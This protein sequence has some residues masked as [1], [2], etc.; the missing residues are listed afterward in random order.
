MSNRAEA[1][2]AEGIDPAA[3]TAW[4]QTLEL[5]AEP[6]LRIARIGAGASNLTYLMTDAAGGR[7]VLRRPPLGELLASAHDIGRE[8]RVLAA[9]EPTEVPTPRIFGLCADPEVS[10]VPLM[11]MEW[12]EGLV[13][14][15]L[16]AAEALSPRLRQRFGLALPAALAQV[17]EV[18]LDATGLRDLSTSKTPYAAR[19]LRRWRGQL[20]QSRTRDVSLLESLGQRLEEA[21]PEQRETR[22]VHGDFH[23]M[24][25]IFSPEDGSVRAILDWELCTL[26]DPLSDLGGLLAY[27]SRPEDEGGAAHRFSLLPG[28]PS[29][30]Q[31]AE[32]YGEASGR[33]LDD[34]GFWH[35]L[36]LWKVAVIS[37][38]VLDRSLRD[39]RNA[40]ALGVPS[41]ELIDGVA[42]R[43]LSVAAAAGF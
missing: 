29:R 12:V 18:D 16:G 34:L 3:V 2:G 40:P 37:E 41:V 1:V 25:A 8:Y 39:P 23:L 36:G 21:I 32:A 14:D 15:D 35:A 19:Q 17:H 13:I 11:A 30:E 24:N 22:L 7:W 9:L 20:E 38:G 33:S 27:W 10:A 28:F 42:R 43:G 4:L 5:G 6:P 26:G 31:L